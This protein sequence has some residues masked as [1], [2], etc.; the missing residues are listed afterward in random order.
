ML[1]EVFCNFFPK[2]SPFLS[3][4]CIGSLEQFNQALA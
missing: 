3:L 1:V 2:V 4:P